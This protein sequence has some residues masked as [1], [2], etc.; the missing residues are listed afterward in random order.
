MHAP[1]LKFNVGSTFGWLELLA[2]AIGHNEEHDKTNVDDCGDDHCS[3]KHEE[4]DLVALICKDD[5]LQEMN[6]EEE[7]PSC[8]TGE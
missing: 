3:H 6:R 5:R 4:V 7:H 1:L 2:D 8:Q